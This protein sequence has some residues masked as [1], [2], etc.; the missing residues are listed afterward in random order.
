MI[1]LAITGCGSRSVGTGNTNTGQDA[2]LPNCQDLWDCNPGVS[3][4]E[5]VMC[6]EGLCRPDLGSVIIPC[7][8][9]EC[10]HDE[11][12]VVALPVTC[13]FGC[14]QVTSRAALADL[15]CFHDE[16]TPP[17]PIAPEC[18]MDCFW[19]PPCIPQPLGARCDDGQCVPRDLGCPD[20]SEEPITGVTTAQLAQDISAHAEQVRWIRGV[21]IPGEGS[22]D[23]E[24][25]STP[26]RSMVNGVVRLDGTLCDLTVDLLGDECRANLL[27]RGVEPGQWYEFQGI[28]HEPPSEYEPPWLEVIGSRLVDP[29]DLG[30]HYPVIVTE[31]QSD[32]NDP[33]CVPPW[34]NVGDTTDVYLARSG[35]QVHL[36]A[37]SFHCEA[38]FSGSIDTNDPEGFTVAMSN[39]CTECDYSVRGTAAEGWLTGEYVIDDG[40]CRY[41]VHFEGT[42]SQ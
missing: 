35:Q 8:F 34:W 40:T 7:T 9:D 41:V 20:F 28:V 42:R 1:G 18:D 12:C 21:V 36:S 22:C 30:G 31:V 17:G 10:T 29:E 33:S 32:G 38:N 27:G 26:Y 23:G 4:G 13:C 14:P 3:C 16:D 5:L 37:P 6:E 15:E 39:G 24:G 19:C 25:C 2:D 11:D